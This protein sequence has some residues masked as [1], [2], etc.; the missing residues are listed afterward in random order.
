MSDENLYQQLAEKIFLKDSVII[1]QLFEMLADAKEAE[2]LLALP[3]TTEGAAEKTGMTADEAAKMLDTLFRKGLVFK[4]VKDEGVI[5]RLCRDLVQFHDATILWP[6]APREFLDLWQKYME[7]EW[8]T[9][10]SVVEKILEK[11]FSRI[12]PVNESID[13][14]QR[15]LAYE[16]VKEMI[17]GAKKIAVT[18]CTCRLIAQKC[19]RPINICLQ[20]D[21]AA[22]YSID[23]GTGR[24]LSK[25]EAMQKIREAEEAGLVHMTMNRSENTHFIC[26]CC[27]DCCQTFPLIISM[28]LHLCDPS[29]FRSQ[30][31]TDLCTGCEDCLDSCFFGAL[32]M[33][34]DDLAVVDYEKCM[35]C[36]LCKVACTE[37]AITLVE[38]REKDFIPT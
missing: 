26:N 37:G 4:K 36:G 9:Y 1:P 23:R 8:P 15:I 32:S 18:N 35:G 19:D 13:A 31:S 24:E 38:A 27:D 16:D 14:T 33:S 5:Y 3:A 34:G 21:R 7:D 25:E 30:V 22:D 29:R 11:P 2:A 28:G 12:V 17:E 6:E 10:A 20:L